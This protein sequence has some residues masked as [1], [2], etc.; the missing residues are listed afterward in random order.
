M[1]GWAGRVLL[2]SDMVVG[3]G[4]DDRAQGGYLYYSECPKPNM[5]FHAEVE[6]NKPTGV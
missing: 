3:E 6:D 4:I 5:I 1:P 2:W